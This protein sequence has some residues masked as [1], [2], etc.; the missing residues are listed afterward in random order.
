[1]EV[2]LLFIVGGGI[3]WLLVWAAN[4]RDRNKNKEDDTL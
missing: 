4:G 1:M 2:I 3:I